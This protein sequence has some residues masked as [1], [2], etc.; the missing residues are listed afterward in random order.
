[1]P[2]KEIT[3]Q[4]AYDLLQ[5]ESD[6]VYIDVRTVPEF[7]SG[8]PAMALNIPVAIHDPNR[9]M[10]MNE[11][12]VAVVE[13]HF[14]KDRKLIVGCQAGPRANAAAKLLQDAGYQEVSSMWGGF[15]GMRNPSGQ[16]VAPGWSTLGYPVS[17]DNGEGVSYESLRAKIR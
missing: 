15:G 12:F 14:P 16:I 7:V 9:G 13:A 11:E 3:V 17:Q 6:C 8:H 2:F 1:M 4:Q 10:T 5:K